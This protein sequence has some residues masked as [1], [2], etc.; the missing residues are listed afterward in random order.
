MERVKVPLSAQE[1]AA[2]A[3]LAE[4]EVRPIPDEI[5]AIVR[6]RLRVAGLLSLEAANAARE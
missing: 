2:L 4:H 1:F 5:R 3:R 6:E